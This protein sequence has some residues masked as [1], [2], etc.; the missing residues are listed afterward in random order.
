MNLKYLVQCC[1]P[2]IYIG[3][4]YSYWIFLIIWGRTLQSSAGEDEKAETDCTLSALSTSR[5][6]PSYQHLSQGLAQSGHEEG[7]R[8]TKRR[9][10]SQ[11][12]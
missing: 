9:A 11:G 3:S 6:P 4:F 7:G 2:H 8:G 5:H 12:S 10:S 1:S